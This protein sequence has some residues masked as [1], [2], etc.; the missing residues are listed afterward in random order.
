MGENHIRKNNQPLPPVILP[1]MSPRA[2]VVPAMA[3]ATRPVPTWLHMDRYL[4]C[5]SRKRSA[6]A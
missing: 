2:I 4:N 3:S 5:L 6:S 1:L